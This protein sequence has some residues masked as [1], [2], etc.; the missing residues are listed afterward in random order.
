MPK[1]P[2]TIPGTDEVA[3]EGGADTIGIMD[4]LGKL[5]GNDARPEDPIAA[6]ENG[7]A[8]AEDIETPKGLP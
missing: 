2:V 3:D 4:V 8:E 6:D 1:Q 5:G 7:S